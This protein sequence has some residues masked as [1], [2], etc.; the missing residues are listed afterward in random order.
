MGERA[1]NMTNPIDFDV[2][3]TDVGMHILILD[4]VAGVTIFD[5]DMAVTQVKQFF[6]RKEL[7]STYK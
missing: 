3:L 7:M 6:I 4:A 5:V 2:H 1:K